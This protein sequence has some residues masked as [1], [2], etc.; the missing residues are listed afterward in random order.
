MYV[1][2]ST[3][4][5]ITQEANIKFS[6]FI[7]FLLLA[8]IIKLHEKTLDLYIIKKKPTKFHSI[9]YKIAVNRFP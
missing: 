1:V 2:I 6:K 5:E 8:E 3:L 7:E 4:G 9:H